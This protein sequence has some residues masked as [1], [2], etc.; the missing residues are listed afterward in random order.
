[1]AVGHLAAAARRH[2]GRVHFGVPAACN[3]VAVDP[4]GVAESVTNSGL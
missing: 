3:T 4:L 1:M 2:V